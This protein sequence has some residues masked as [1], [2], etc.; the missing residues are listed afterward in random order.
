LRKKPS[1]P[2]IV[3]TAEENKKKHKNTNKENKNTNSAIKREQ[4]F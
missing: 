4:K 3:Q 2:I 1:I